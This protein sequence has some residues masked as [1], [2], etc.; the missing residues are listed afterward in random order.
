MPTQL[1]QLKGNTGYAPEFG[2]FEVGRVVSGVKADGLCDEHKKLCV[3]LFSKT[4]ELKDL[5][6]QLRDMICVAVDE[7]KHNSLTFSALEASHSYQHPKNL[8]AILCDD[9]VLGEIGVVYPAV[10]KKIDKK[11]SIVYAEIDV[12]ALSKLADAGI[13]YEE[14]S[15][16][17]GMEVDLTF[18]SETYAPIRDAIAAANSPLLKKV[19]L[20]GTYA[21]ENGASITVR[22]TFSCMDRT[23]TGEEVHRVT[24]TIIETL[25]AQGIRL[26]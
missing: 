6:F 24:D 8:N 23:L 5:Y 26:K 15:K 14:T 16:Y 4:K 10:S 17:P 25:A 13:R 1:C 22:L 2:L 7:L 12:L 21:D 11:A 20:V 9:V 3:T 19:R 18:L